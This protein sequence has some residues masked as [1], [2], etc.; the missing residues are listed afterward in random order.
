[1]SFK[2]VLAR[3]GD[4]VPDLDIIVFANGRQQTAGRRKGNGTDRTTAKSTKKLVFA[5]LVQRR[6]PVPVTGPRSLVPIIVPVAH[7]RASGIGMVAAIGIFMR[8][9]TIW[10]V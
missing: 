9:R 10:V 4:W 6:L 8:A 3:E 7:H 2:R 5:L 1:M